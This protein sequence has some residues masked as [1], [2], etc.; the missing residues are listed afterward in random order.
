MRTRFVCRCLLCQLEVHLKRQLSEA[1]SEQNFSKVAVSSPLLSGFPNASALTAHLRSCRSNGNG[2][3]PADPILI[4]VLHLWHRTA[5]TLLRDVLLLAFIP[6]LHT[7]S[8]QVAQRYPLLSTEDTLQH[9][10]A[11]L[12]ETFDSPKLL[13]RD[14]HVAF[15]ISRMAKRS[16]FDWAKRQTQ[17]PGSADHDQLLTES[18]VSGIPEPLERAVLLR[19][20]LCRCQ[21][22]G[23]LTGAEIELLVHIKLEGHLRDTN[24]E[25]SN[26]LRQR[27]KRMLGKLRHAA[28]V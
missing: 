25:Y 24:G 16:T 22:E 19:H 20:F 11:A 17:T 10:V 13:A 2:S 23:L 1:R 5:D 27:I 3:H 18:P 26:A 9:L 15:A 28:S 7:A 8:R 12:L 21:R 14:S 4:E 6:V